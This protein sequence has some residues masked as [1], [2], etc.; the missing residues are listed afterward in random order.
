M[1]KSILV[2]DLEKFKKE[3]VIHEVIDQYEVLLD[4]LFHV[5]NP[6]TKIKKDFGTEYKIFV[7][8]HLDGRPISQAGSWFYFPWNKYL[9]HYLPDDLHQEIRSAR[10]RELISREDQSKLYNTTIAACGLSVG[11][12]GVFILAMMGIARHIKLADPDFISASNL[13]RLNF[14]FTKISKN[15]AQVIAEHIYQVNPYAI[16]EVYSNGV[17]VENVEEFLNG[18]DI[19]VEE[20]DSLPV[21]IMIREKARIKG[22]PVLMATD[23]GTGAIL[24]VERFDQDKNRPLFHGLVE[25]TKEFLSPEMRSTN[26]AEWNKIANKIIGVEFMEKDLLDSLPKIGQSISGVPQLGAAAAMSG[27][28]LATCVLKIVR[29]EPVVSGKYIFSVTN[30]L[31]QGPVNTHKS[32]D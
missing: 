10:N 17:T 25:I 14:D 15:K 5:R 32:H 16:I 30:I 13:N 28:L 20:M 24:D 31:A 29:G 1:E 21:K 11:S 12:H 9:V 19:L 4:E 23:N 22:I 26:P 3:N 6:W 18:V 2:T 7:S 27:S 8:E